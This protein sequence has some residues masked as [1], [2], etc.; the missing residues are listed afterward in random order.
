MKIEFGKEICQEFDLGIKKEWIETNTLGAYSSSTIYGL[1][2]R[3]YHGLFVIP[4]DSIYKRINV[5][6]KLEESIFVENR[7][8]EISTNQFIGGVYPDGYKFLKKFSTI[9]SCINL[10]KWL[11]QKI[12]KN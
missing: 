2:T 4:E 9:N 3:R 5:L 10:C 1:N 12:L 11:Q 6:S 8:Y 7:I